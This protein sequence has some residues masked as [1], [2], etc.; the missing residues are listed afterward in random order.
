MKKI[1]VSL[2]LLLS[3]SAAYSQIELFVSKQG[4]DSNKGT[5][6]AP[7]LSLEKALQ[8][9]RKTDKDVIIYLREGTYRPQQTIVLTPKDA[10]AKKS[11]RICS[12]QGEKTIISGGQP[13]KLKW[14]KYKE[15]N[16]MQAHIK[17]DI[18]IDMLLVNGE[19]AHMARYPNFDTTAIR[20]NGVSEEATAPARVTKWK[21]P[22]TGYLH[23]MHYHDW[24]SMHYRITGVNDKKELLLKGGWQNN[25]NYGIH[26]KYR[27]VENI[28]EE[29]DAP[30]EWFFD[31]KLQT[32]YY[33]PEANENMSDATVEV[34]QLKHL[35]EIRGTEQQPV[36]NITLEGLHFTETQR[37]FMENYEPLLRS[38]W[39]IYR[40]SAIFL[41]GTENCT[42]KNCDLYNLG[43]NAVFF[44]RYNRNGKVEGS[45]FK[46]IGASAICF[47]GDSS[48]VR[49][50]S[51]EYK[52]YVSYDKMDKG[53]GPLNNK[54]PANCYATD[55][56]I[57]HIGLFEKQVTGVELSMCQS[58]TVSHNSIY[59]VPRSGI[60][61]SEGTWG[62]H[63]IE[64]NDVFDT[65]KET[66]DHGSFNSWGRDRFWN[67]HYN[68]TASL[69]AQHPEMIL[70][71]AEKTTILRN[72][73]FRCDRGWDIDLDDGSSNYH[74]YNNLCLNGGLKL[75]EGFYR[76]VENNILINNTFH[77]HVWFKN[78]G[79]IF[80]RNIVMKKYKP[81]Q[82]RQWGLMVDFNLFTDST[83][84]HAAHA[85]H[86]DKHSIVSAIQFRNPEK[87]DF[88]VTNLTPSIAQCGFHNFPMDQFGV[89]SPRLKALARTPEITLPIGSRQQ[90]Q[91]EQTIKWQGL[92]LKN[93]NSL[94]ERSATG[95]DAE[96]GVYVLAVEPSLKNQSAIHENDVILEIDH[97]KTNNLK[98]WSQVISKYKSGDQITIVVFR[99][100]TAQSITLNIR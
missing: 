66:G 54:Y 27:M 40:G 75:R 46:N 79:D 82:I 74:I 84:L 68:I 64:F 95:M 13:L 38:D 96:R 29:L 90:H 62:G 34:A 23:V 37:T 99:N 100:Q 73:R 89:S 59:D 98:E 51:F 71:D 21:H 6:N 83:A 63:L 92:H 65:V 24:G 41:E 35:I 57:H 8:E 5:I 16:F 72:N 18:D 88:T 14:K 97:K 43:G 80:T 93:L 1:F 3:S 31:K 49:S 39:T 2:L 61:V 17:K 20:F 9:A 47:V 69:A 81:V 53:N 67:P 44:S 28:F 25:R 33:Y 26:K 60:N 15:C 87:G 22:E 10:N 7:F 11:L 85:W 19:I 77:P 55:N 45:L 94:G 30:R 76:V 56:L 4:K 58:I 52:Q 86:T 12:Y 48:A 78:S 36:A 70:K 50:P 91:K 42:I 32:L